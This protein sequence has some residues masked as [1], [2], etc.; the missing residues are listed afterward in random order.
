MSSQFF[1]GIFLTLVFST[2]VFSTQCLKIYL[3]QHI[4][5]RGHLS[6]ARLLLVNCHLAA[7]DEFVDRR[8]A[9]YHRICAGLF[10][11]P[12]AATAAAAA[13]AGQ[14]PVPA[15]PTV[16][17]RV[18]PEP[19]GSGGSLSSAS[20]SSY[21]SALMSSPFHT[22]EAARCLFLSGSDCDYGA[23]SRSL[24]PCPLL[25]ALISRSLPA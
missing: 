5:A 22:G 17:R 7:H 10:S 24:C 25:P 8:N 12:P 20:P 4:K 3:K 19:E 23:F 21:L 11:A 15:S 14:P 1:S 13:T 16:G 6:G 2:L 18:A 9:D